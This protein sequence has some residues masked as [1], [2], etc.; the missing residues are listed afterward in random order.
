MSFGFF[1]KNIRSLWKLMAC[2]V[3]SL[4][5]P[6]YRHFLKCCAEGFF[7]AI[8]PSGNC[9]V[10][11]TTED[12]RRSLSLVSSPVLIGSRRD[13]PE[14]KT[15]TAIASIPRLQKAPLAEHG[16]APLQSDKTAFSYIALMLLMLNNR[17][18]K[19]SRLKH[20]GHPHMSTQ[21]VIVTLSSYFQH[22]KIPLAATW[23]VWRKVG[24]VT[25]VYQKPYRSLE[26]AG[27]FL[28][29]LCLAHNSSVK[30]NIS[31]LSSTKSVKT[32]GEQSHK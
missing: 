25:N 2:L 30:Q 21:N 19:R 24:L 5:S 13:V 32:T 23:G 6:L 15:W 8:I 28:I 29:M 9:E 17:E 3:T 22:F 20:I 12:N 1:G 16:H 27:L 14:N 7:V 31:M 11:K 26:N 18:E 10:K 4:I